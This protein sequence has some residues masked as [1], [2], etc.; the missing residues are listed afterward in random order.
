MDYRHYA[1]FDV[2]ICTAVSNCNPD[3]WL[4]DKGIVA[5]QDCQ[6]SFTEWTTCDCPTCA[7]DDPERRETRTF[8]Q[9]R[10]ATNP[11][12][13][14]TGKSRPGNAPATPLLG[15]RAAGRKCP[16]VPGRT[17]S[18]R[19][20]RSRRRFARSRGTSRQTTLGRAIPIRAT[21]TCA[22]APVRGGYLV[23]QSTRAPAGSNRPPSK[24]SSRQLGNQS[25]PG[26]PR[27]SSPEAC[28][29][30]GHAT[31]ERINTC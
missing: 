9:T 29:A 20:T 22:R 14:R 12:R 8:N 5:P 27:R 30:R 3:R 13:Q 31:A 1:W 7:D 4:A 23:Y 24:K 2:G 17:L 18:P 11:A 21:G 19:C 26:P 6:G 28:N 10:P 16:R 15:G 25:F